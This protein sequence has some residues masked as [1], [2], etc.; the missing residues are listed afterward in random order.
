M[1]FSAAPSPSSFHHPCIKVQPVNERIFAAADSLI[2]A[3]TD[4]YLHKPQ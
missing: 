3:A 1:P 2:V 4:S